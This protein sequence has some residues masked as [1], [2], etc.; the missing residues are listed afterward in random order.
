ME[1][2]NQVDAYEDF[3]P[4]PSKESDSDDDDDDVQF[5]SRVK[6]NAYA[7]VDHGRCRTAN[8]L[9]TKNPKPLGASPS[10]IQKSNA[11]DTGLKT[12]LGIENTEFPEEDE[13]DDI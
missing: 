5:M 10:K 7:S 11:K 1:V 6:A 4:S 12:S 13:D 2:D 8:S 3:N 9:H